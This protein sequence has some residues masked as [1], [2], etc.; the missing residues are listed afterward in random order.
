MLAVN[1]MMSALASL[2]FIKGSCLVIFSSVSLSLARARMMPPVRGTRRPAT[3]KSPLPLFLPGLLLP[4]KGGFGFLVYRL[5]YRRSRSSFLCFLWFGNQ[6]WFLTRYPAGYQIP[7]FHPAVED[8]SLA[9]P[10]QCIAVFFQLAGCSYLLV[11]GLLANS[12]P[13]T[14]A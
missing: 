6:L 7:S 5:L 9:Q 1:S 10:H 4:A 12:P 2:C 11:E 8:K 13:E 3:R 14:F